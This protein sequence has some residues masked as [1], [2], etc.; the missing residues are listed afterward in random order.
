MGKFNSKNKDISFKRD[1]IVRIISHYK[2]GG[3]STGT[4]F[5]VNENR[6]VLTCW[7]V[8]CGIDLK[9]LKSIP[10]FQQS[11]KNTESKKVD[12]YFKNKTSKIEVELPNGRKLRAILKSYDYYYDLAVLGIPKSGEKI[13]FFELEL[14]KS[15]DYS[16]EILFCGYPNCPDYGLLESPFAVNTGIVSTFP[17]VE[18]AGG[19]YKGIQLNSICVGGN[20]GAPLF[21]K[22]SNK[23]C[24]IINGYRWQGR[25]DLAIY[26][27]DGSL[28]QGGLRVPISISYATSF[29]RLM[30]ESKILKQ[31]IKA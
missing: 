5:L 11:T 28:E 30:K 2:N 18:I 21:K 26:K 15:L 17:D 22:D 20:S 16:D 10:E 31:L 27:K 4:G 23:P 13:P 29:Y 7:H 8:I 6:N 19:K 3:Y 9:I 14:N 25:D 24:G 1:R 12:E